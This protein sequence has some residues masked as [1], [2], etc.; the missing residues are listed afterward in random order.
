MNTCGVTILVSGL[1]L[2]ALPANAEQ[3]KT[4]YLAWAK[5]GSYTISGNFRGKVET[6]GAR[7]TRD[8]RI[9]IRVPGVASGTKVRKAGRCLRFGFK[10]NG[11]KR[12]F[13][14][15]W[16]NTVGYLPW[17]GRRIKARVRRTGRIASGGG[18]LN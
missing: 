1:I 3:S 9:H 6:A 7:L 12:A 11:V 15:K 13:T 5:P 2:V 16:C 10:I 14:A 18:A 8:C 4:C 17:K